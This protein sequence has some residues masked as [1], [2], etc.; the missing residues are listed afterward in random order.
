MDNLN[1]QNENEYLREVDYFTPTEAAYRWSLKRNTVIAALNRGRFNAYLQE[2]LVKKFSLEGSTDWYITAKA[3]REVFGPEDKVQVF[4][5]WNRVGDNSKPKKSICFMG[6]NVYI[7]EGGEEI[8]EDVLEKM[9]TTENYREA[10]RV[11]SE[12]ICKKQNKDFLIKVERVDLHDRFVVNY[13]DFFDA[14]RMNDTNHGTELKIV[15]K[16]MREALERN[17]FIEFTRLST[18][19]LSKQLI[20]I[21]MGVFTTFEELDDFESSLSE[22]Q[23][24]YV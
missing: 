15:L 5:L 14:H 7:A 2:G 23:K 13:T 1:G 8:P 6:K 17:K 20:T 19:I 22:I 24:M 4:E 21:R 10:R 11:I 16:E 9:R 3:M 12:Y 18:N